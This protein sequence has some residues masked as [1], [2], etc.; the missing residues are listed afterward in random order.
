MNWW[1]RKNLLSY[2]LWPLSLLWQWTMALRR[3]L[4]KRGVFSTTHFSVPII[5][6]GNLTVGGNGKTPVIIA[7]FQLLQEM[8]FRPGIVSRGYGGALKKGAYLVT[9]ASNARLVGDEPL[10]LARRLNCPLAI[11]SQRVEA[12]NLLLAH[13]DCDVVLS[14]DGLQHLAMGRA[15]ELIVVDGQRQ[16]GNGFCLPAGPLRESIQRLHSTPWVLYHSTDPVYEDHF[17][18]QPHGFCSVTNPELKRSLHAFVNQTVEVVVA[19]GYP[20]RFL[21]A[22]QTLG[23]KFNAKIFKD[24]HRYTAEELAAYKNKTLLM[25]EKDAVKC[26]SFDLADAWYLE[27]SA[28]LSE[29]L[30]SRL[31]EH[32]LMWKNHEHHLW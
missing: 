11:G 23:I 32:F 30:Q 18:L 1:Y 4:Y 28:V 8:G 9:A 12:V 3:N 15:M 6:V 31:R 17:F 21:D 27:V 22:L 2:L 25:T 19:I 20:Q 26:T 14:D 13:H 5:V 10:L 16:F 29:S 24:H 7:L